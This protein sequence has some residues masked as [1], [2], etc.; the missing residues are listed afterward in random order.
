[1]TVI[2]SVRRANA[3]FERRGDAEK[4]VAQQTQE[5]EAARQREASRAA[6]REARRQAD[7]ARLADH[8][9]RMDEIMRQHRSATEAIW[10][11]GRESC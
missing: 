1:M 4:Q 11:K 9:A 5:A 2:E 8:N 10:G 3:K 6:E 7:A